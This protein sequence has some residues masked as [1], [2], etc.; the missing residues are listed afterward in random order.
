MAR[1]ELREHLRNANE[2]R[3]RFAA[4]SD[5]DDPVRE[6]HIDDSAALH[7]ATACDG[8]EVRLVRRRDPAADS[9]ILSTM[10]VAARLS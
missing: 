2:Q 6:E 3:S 10:E 7:G 1:F 5:R 9:A 8:E 4:R